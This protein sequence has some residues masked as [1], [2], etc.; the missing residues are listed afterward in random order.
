MV[1]TL[2]RPI[3][4]KNFE[5]LNSNVWLHNTNGIYDDFYSF[6]SHL[7]FKSRSNQT[8]VCYNHNDNYTSEEASENIHIH[9]RKITWSNSQVRRWVDSEHFVGHHVKVIYLITCIIHVLTL[10]YTKKIVWQYTYIR[11]RVYSTHST[12]VYTRVN[13]HRAY[14]TVKQ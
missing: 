4:L 6:S 14:S 10:Q 3:F 12:I 8:H 9:S 1:K 11:I 7:F 5:I 13:I 2:H